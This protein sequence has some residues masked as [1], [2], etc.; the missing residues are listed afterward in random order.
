MLGD[1]IIVSARLAGRCVADD[2]DFFKEGYV[3]A[4]ARGNLSAQCEGVA[5]FLDGL[6]NDAALGYA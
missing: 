6:Q 4:I 5:I 3:G 2:V 1:A